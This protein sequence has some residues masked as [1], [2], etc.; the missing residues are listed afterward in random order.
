MLIVQKMLKTKVAL[1]DHMARL[2]YG[3]KFSCDSCNRKYV[4]DPSVHKKE[5]IH[6]CQSCNNAFRTKS[7]LERHFLAVHEKRKDF[8][9]SSCFKSFFDKTYLK[10][11][12]SKLHSKNPLQ[13][14]RSPLWT[15][16]G[17]VFCSQRWTV[18]KVTKWIDIELL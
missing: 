18:M 17:K 13:S 2:H 12:I 1:E 9:C 15:S 4:H 3:T 11:H 10:K 14:D 5:T 7:K 16:I 6:S 8:Q